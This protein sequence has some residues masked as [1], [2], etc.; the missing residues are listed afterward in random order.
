MQRSLTAEL[1]LWLRGPVDLVFQFAAARPEALAS[2]SILFESEGQH[3]P[4][5]EVVDRC[6]SRLQRVSGEGGRLFARYEAVVDGRAE[7]LAASEV[8]TLAYLR[9]SRYAPAD[10]VYGETSRFRGLRGVDLLRAVDAFVAERTTYAPGESYGTDT[11]V[12]TLRTGRGVC[13]DYAHLVIALLRAL[14]VPARYVA[15]YA[16]GLDPMDFH[17]VAEALLDGVW[18]AL[19]ATR[20]ADR[21][22]LVRIA[23]GRDAADCSF[24]SN[25]G[26]GASLRSLCVDAQA[27]DADVPRLGEADADDHAELVV[28]S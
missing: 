22:A 2:E 11:A 21:R 5:T 16:P 20:L 17:A 26:A 4:F 28:I 9:P 6:G 8:E 3:L 18:Y 24:L 25:Y 10:E 14:D 12:T 13:R 15:C 1:D 23:T 27:S 7:A 19:D